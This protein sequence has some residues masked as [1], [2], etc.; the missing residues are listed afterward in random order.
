MSLLWIIL[1]GVLDDRFNVGDW[2]FFL[3]TGL[4]VAL[5]FTRKSRGG[6]RRRVEIRGDG[7]SLAE[8]NKG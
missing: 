6:R 7:L 1:E 3:R 5:H 4:K 8:L 2:I